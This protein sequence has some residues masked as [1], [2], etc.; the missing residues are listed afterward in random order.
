MQ[1]KQAVEALVGVPD[2]IARQDLLG[3]D[4]GVKTTSKLLV[5]AHK[6]IQLLR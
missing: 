5:S 2:V 1:I 4:E 6:L 3:Y